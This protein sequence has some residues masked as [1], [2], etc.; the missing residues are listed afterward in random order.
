LI[1]AV[2]KDNRLT[3]S[4]HFWRDFARSRT[5]LGV[6]EAA[7]TAVM[8]ILR[9]RVFEPAATGDNFTSRG[10][11]GAQ[12]V[13]ERLRA[14]WKEYGGLPFDERMM[15]VLTDPKGNPESWREAAANLASLGQD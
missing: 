15:K 5:V 14:Y 3:R 8:S 12:S 10:K 11:E 4:V 7:L 2:D 6:R 13:A 9:V 1:D